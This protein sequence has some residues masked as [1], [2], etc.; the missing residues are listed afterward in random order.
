MTDSG[1]YLLPTDDFSVG[2]VVEQQ[3]LR[4]VVMKRFTRIRSTSNDYSQLHGVGRRV[5][6]A[7]GGN[8]SSEGESGVDK[9][10]I[11]PQ[12]TVW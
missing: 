5:H 11:K 7:N 9:A 6:F 4:D 12:E 10:D 2:N 1:H 3:R 8:L